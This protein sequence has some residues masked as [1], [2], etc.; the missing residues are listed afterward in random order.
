MNAHKEQNQKEIEITVEL[1]WDELKPY[2]DKASEKI[3]ED[4]KVEGFRPGKVPYDV[5][6]NKVG[7]MAILQ[8]AA[9]MAIQKTAEIVLRE[10]FKDLSAQASGG[11]DKA[12]TDS[13]VGRPEVKLTKVAAGNPLEYKVVLQRAPEVTLGKYKDLKIKEEAVA[14]TDEE[15]EK[16]ISQ[17]RALRASEK[18]VDRAVQEGD[19]A[20]VNIQMF[21]DNVPL[22]GGQ[23]QNTAVI[24]GADY[25]IPGFDKKLLGA[26][27]GETREFKLLYPSGHYQKNIAGK[28]VEFKV[29]VKEIYERVLPELND[30]FA[31]NAGAKDSNDLKQKIRDNLET[32][33]KQKNEEKVVIELFE[34]IL[35]KTTF[36]HLPE[37][38][39]HSE[40]HNMI[41]ELKHSVEHQ[42]GK[43][44]DYLLHIKKTESELEKE[45]EP[46]AEKRVKTSFIVNAIVKAE[47]ITVT[48]EDLQKKIDDLLKLY[49]ASPEAQA[50]VETADYRDYVKHNLLN[51]KVIAQLKEW[52]VKK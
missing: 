10:Q 31:K 6:K 22:E 17:L 29:E 51:Q 16:V 41:H 47:N 1:S 23:S 28:M 5:L 13:I 43:F 11:A 35:G 36:S 52:N 49:E 42:G 38:L 33:G 21:L 30:E 50:Q 44:A 40:T 12:E 24:M 8:E 37:Q 7:E 25:I 15:V 18:I 39:V 32:E 48:D 27:K 45:L 14:V 9:D 2:L 19:K 4:V 20:L 34:K 3:S 46:E 26:A